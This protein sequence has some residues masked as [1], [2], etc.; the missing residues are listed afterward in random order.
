MVRLEFG[1]HGWG[2]GGGEIRPE[3]MDMFG[4]QTIR[5]SLKRMKDVR[6]RKVN[7]YN[8]ILSNGKYRAAVNAAGEGSV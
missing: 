4:R 1:G 7:N 3:I 5:I 6:E 8:S 2:I